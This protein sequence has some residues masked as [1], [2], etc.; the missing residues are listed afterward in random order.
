M[1]VV[2]KKAYTTMALTEEL[3]RTQAFC[4]LRK[5][6]SDVRLLGM[7]MKKAAALKAE[8]EKEKNK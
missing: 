7:R 8:Q 1:P 5:A 4:T 2:D 6:R 3:K